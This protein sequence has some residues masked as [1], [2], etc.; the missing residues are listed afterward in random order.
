MKKMFDRKNKQLAILLSLALSLGTLVPFTADAQ[1]G[2]AVGYTG[3]HDSQRGQ[4]YMLDYRPDGQPWD[5]TAGA[6]RGTHSRDTSFIAAS[7]EIVDQHLY[8]S[9]G[10]AL[11]RHQTSTLSSQ[12]QFMTTF[13]FHHDGWSLAVRHMSNGGLRGSNVGENAVI[14]EWD[15]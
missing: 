1:T 10:P 7:Y 4:V 2:I 13:G 3:M 12:Y 15:L 6:I 9:F 11:I 5:F 8:A 14:L